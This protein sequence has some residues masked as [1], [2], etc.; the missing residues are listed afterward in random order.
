MD[1]IDWCLWKKGGLEIIEPNS[2]VSEAYVKKAESSLRSMRVVTEEEWVISMAYY[3]MYLAVYALMIKI[4]VKCEM[5]SCSIEFVKVFLG[6]YF[7]EEEVAF[8][9]KSLQARIDKQYYTD[10]EVSDEQYQAM[11]KRAQEYLIKAKSILMQISEKEINDIRNRVMIRKT[12]RGKKDLEKPFKNAK[13]SR[14][15]QRISGEEIKKE[16]EKQ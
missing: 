14:P 16:R 1:K 5:H 8:L 11:T 10:R 4:G 13:N 3:A 15:V 7:N 12:N 6:K 9:K 2:N